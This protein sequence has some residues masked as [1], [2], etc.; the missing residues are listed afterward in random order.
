VIHAVLFGA[1]G[2]IQTR[3]N[4]RDFFSPLHVV[5]LVDP[6]PARKPAGASDARAPRPKSPEKKKEPTPKPPL[7]SEP[8]PKA[9]PQ[10]SPKPDPVVKTPNPTV[11]QPK[12]DPAQ[13]EQRVAK[14][15]DDLRKKLQAARPEPGAPEGG[16]RAVRNKIDAMRKRLGPEGGG[17]A[18]K[19]S[20]TP[21][22]GGTVTPSALQEVR[23]R[24]YYNRLWEHVH[25]HW[26]IPP[27]LEGKPYTV[28]VSVVIDR[29]GRL[30]KSWVEEPSG[31]ELF[32]KSALNALLLAEPLP[33]M[34]DSVTEESLEI[35]FRFHGE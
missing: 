7:Q 15:I 31:S 28:I 21:A 4:A 20:E 3:Q 1:F 13:S 26:A 32:D 11:I 30:L 18:Q 2:R 24:A 12:P 8:I 10:P 27:P 6:G 22:G 5:D 16:E 29:Q 33:P 19:D 9:K 23:L 17:N 25:G 34:P 35:G 14:R